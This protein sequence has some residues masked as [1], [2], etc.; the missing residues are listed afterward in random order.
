M[1]MEAFNLRNPQA[2]SPHF[3]EITELTKLETTFEIIK[4]H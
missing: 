4:Q 3:H 1:Y 2:S